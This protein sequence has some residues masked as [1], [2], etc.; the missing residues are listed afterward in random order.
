MTAPERA[1]GI[2]LGLERIARFLSEVLPYDPRERLRVVH[3]AGTNGK[4]SVCALV[5]EALTAAGYKVGTF[6]SP[7]FLEPN[8]A[9]RIMGVPIAEGEYA[10]LRKW[11]REVDAKAQPPDGTLT[12]FEQTAAA[13]FWWFAERSVD[14]A[15]IEVGMG[16]LRDA[17][18]LFGPADGKNPKGVGRSLVQCICPIDNDHLGVIGNTIEEIACEKA[19]IMRP[20]SWIIIANQDHAD[21]FHKIRQLAHRTSPGRIINVRRQPSYDIHVPDFSIVQASGECT[22]LRP[23]VELPSWSAF[24]GTGRRCLRVKYPPSLDTYTKPSHRHYANSV[25]ESSAASSS[26]S[27]SAAKARARAQ[28]VGADAKTAANA[29]TAADSKPEQVEINLPL[30]LPGYYQAGNA[31]VAFYALDV[32]RTKFGFTRLTD[33]AIQVGFQNVRWPGRLSWLDLASRRAAHFGTPAPSTPGDAG[34]SAAR[35][36]S[37]NSACSLGSGTTDLTESLGSWVLV[38]GAHNEPAAAELRKYVDTTLRLI[39]QQRYIRA[40]RALH[41]QEA[42]RVR[43]IVG[44]SKGK[45]MAAILGRLLRPGDVLWTVPFSQPKDMP[46]VKC[47]DPDAIARTASELPSLDSIAAESFGQLADVVDR[48]A[49]DTSDVHLNVVC[50]SLYLAADAFRTLQIHPF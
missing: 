28:P 12:L 3:V 30:A 36:N 48:L 29:K 16:G 40:T 9:L 21:A 5:S 13:A 1:S 18:N 39:S 47:A 32:L 37:S 38:D 11:I 23:P 50:G 26:S 41:A 33:A 14:I 45:D 24:Q 20:E 17:T 2:A 8:D 43:W 31:S 44:F 15:V 7:H 35:S 25:R 27:S 46:W 6:N 49:A 42:L 34:I 19:G 22:A 4:G 10:A